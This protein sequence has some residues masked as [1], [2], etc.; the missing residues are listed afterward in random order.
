MCVSVTLI[1]L[2]RILFSISL[3]FVKL[4]ICVKAANSSTL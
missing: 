1:K 3:R 4:C 2:N